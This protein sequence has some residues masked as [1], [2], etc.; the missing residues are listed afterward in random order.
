[1]TMRAFGQE[2][3]GACAIIGANSPGE[4]YSPPNLVKPHQAQGVKVTLE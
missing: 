4:R 2:Q 1:M 3:E